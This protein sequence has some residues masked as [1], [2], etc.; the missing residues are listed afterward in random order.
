MNKM[1]IQAE[2]GFFFFFFFFGTLEP[3][4]FVNYLIKIYENL[5]INEKP[6]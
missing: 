4:Q 6:W 1:V 5:N 3:D 2:K